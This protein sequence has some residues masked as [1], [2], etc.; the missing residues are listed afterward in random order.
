MA[1]SASRA[2]QGRMHNGTA[3]QAGGKQVT[4]W[5]AG[6]AG[7]PSPPET[8]TTSGPSYVPLAL[9]MAFK[10][11]RV[12]FM[13]RQLT[14]RLVG[15]W[16]KSAHAASEHREWQWLHLRARTCRSVAGGNGQQAHS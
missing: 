5:Q 2:A 9:K 1:A 14:S 8:S 11:T 12:P 10:V 4:G 3:W 6:G 7:H 13:Q 16:E 15:V